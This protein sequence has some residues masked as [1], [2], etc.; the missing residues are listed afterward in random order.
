MS[1]DVELHE[2]DPVDAIWFEGAEGVRIGSNSMS[3]TP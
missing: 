1:L 3:F 2:I